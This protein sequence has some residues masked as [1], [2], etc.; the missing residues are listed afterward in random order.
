[1]QQWALLMYEGCCKN[2]QPHLDFPQLG[3]IQ[4]DTLCRC[5]RD[6]TSLA[7]HKRDLWLA[8]ELPNHPGYSIRNRFGFPHSGCHLLQPPDGLWQ[9]GLSARHCPRG[10]Q[11]LLAIKR[12]TKA[13]HN[14][15]VGSKPIIFTLCAKK[16]F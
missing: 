1:M 9:C 5:Y 3:V 2:A 12:G 8:V 16:A 10:A 14:L 11:K 13:L 6:D 15:G 4:E 7:I